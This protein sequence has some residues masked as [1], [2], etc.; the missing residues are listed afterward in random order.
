MVKTVVLYY[1]SFPIFPNP[2]FFC[3]PFSFVPTFTLKFLFL[4]KMPFSS[5]NRL[6]FSTLPFDLFQITWKLIIGILIW[7]TK[8]PRMRVY[9]CSMHRLACEVNVLMAVIAF[10]KCRIKSTF[11]KIFRWRSRK[12]HSWY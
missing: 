2:N 12:R 3:F 10:L 1:I 6:K 8:G 11:K 9:I 7:K 4:M 5:K